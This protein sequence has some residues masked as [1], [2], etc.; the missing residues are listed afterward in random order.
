MDIKGL[1]G[2]Q[3]LLISVELKPLQGERFQPT[4]F[5]DIGAATYSAPDGTK[6]LLI[7]SAQSMAN[8]MEAVCW[9]ESNNTLIQQLKGLTYITVID[10]KSKK[11][12]TNSILEAHRINSVYITK[13]DGSFINKEFTEVFGKKGGKTIPYTNEKRQELIRMLFKY[14][15]GSLL[16]G[17]FMPKYAN[18]RC[19]IARALSGFVEAKNVDEVISGGTK[20][21]SINPSKG[22]SGGAEEG[23][24]N[25][26]FPRSE[27][28]GE[29]TAFF[30]LDL[31]QIRSYKLDQNKE[32]MLILLSL[33]KIRKVLEDGLRFRTA[34]DLKVKKINI[35]EPEGFM[36]PELHEISEEL[37]KLIKEVYKDPSN[38]S[39][40][41]VEYPL[42]EKMDK[43]KK[44]ST[45]E[46]EEEEES[47]NDGN[48][49]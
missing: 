43:G 35:D 48:G 47:D 41:E 20:F 2:K 13:L 17:V 42:E 32:D 24:G 18:G 29:I 12:L 23:F 39:P 6:M 36:L 46:E 26:P 40:S 34:C 1:E 22:K 30:N 11:Q 44:S 31:D 3:R 4:G 15:V 14:D 19:R 7:E 33:F 37:S 25:I 45:T 16:H 21:D 9:D 38:N 28:T 49:Q 10:K 27:Y 5:P 8:R